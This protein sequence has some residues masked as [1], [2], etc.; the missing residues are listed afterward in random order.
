VKST[1]C[2]LLCVLTSIAICSGPTAR[3]AEIRA[4]VAVTDVTPPVG[5]RMSGY[6]HERPATGTHDPLLAKAIVFGNGD[7]RAA[8]V[9]CDLIGL[10]RDLSERIRTAAEKKTGIPVANVL[11]A[12]THT[13]TGPLYFGALRQQFHDA[14]VADGSDDPREKVDFPAMLTEKLVQVIADAQ[15]A[16]VPV[17]LH[18]G[19]ARQQGLSFNRRFHLK[20]G[21]VRFNPGVLNPNIVRTAGPIDPDVGIVLL[22][23]VA[24]DG[25]MAS[26]TVFALHLDTVGGTLYSADYPYYLQQSLSKK[27]GSK[28]VSLFGNGTC[29]DINHIDVTQRERLKTQHIGETLAATVTAELPRLKSVNRPTVT[30][31]REIVVAPLQQFSDEEVARARQTMQRISSG[32]VPFMDR[33]TAYK[34][35]AVRRRGGETMPLEVQ[36]FRLG[37]DLA[38]VGLPGEVFVD[39]G[40][41]IK[42]ASPFAVT[43]VIELC[44]DAPGYIPTSKAFAEGSYETVNSRIQSGSGEK[45]AEAAVR[46]LKQ[47]KP[48]PE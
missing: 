14:A 44:Q 15:A 47:L 36:V 42:R 32:D 35:L 5:Y 31:R 11:L 38:V 26:L 3:G 20:D 33:V 12:A 2:G 28:F 21:T 25:P 17:T 18:A 43:L 41:Q 30:V 4:G 27:L 23:R 40:L 10:P 34:I 48:A 39:L 16:S 6:F 19:I 22:R 8:M 1:F 24:D 46:L 37:E 9:F 29:G 13:H 45:M 7:D